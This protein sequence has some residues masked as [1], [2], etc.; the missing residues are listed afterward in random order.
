MLVCARRPGQHHRPRTRPARA[1]G[2]ASSH[3]RA[4][5]SFDDSYGRRPENDRDPP[6]VSPRHEQANR[7]SPV[8][9]RF[10]LPP[11]VGIGAVAS[12]S[13]PP[14]PAERRQVWEWPSEPDLEEA[15]GDEQKIAVG[16]GGDGVN[17]CSSRHA[18]PLVG[19][20]WRAASSRRRSGLVLHTVDPTE[21][22]GADRHRLAPSAPA[23]C[24][25]VGSR[26]R[27]VG[28]ARRSR[29]RRLVR[30]STPAMR[31]SLSRVRPVEKASQRTGPRASPQAPP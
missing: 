21:E 20:S 29:R 9:L 24:R 15:R 25:C 10:P 31:R 13:P 5:P 7:R 6:L 27:C 8:V 19:H 16:I 14:R 1:R 23:V 30:V 11:Q 28:Y 22:S 2:A 18:R 12:R 17:P 26:E 3:V 4:D